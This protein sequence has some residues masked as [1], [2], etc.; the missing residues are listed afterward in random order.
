VLGKPV[1]PSSRLEQCANQ[2]VRPFV[3]VTSAFA[4]EIL[5]MLAHWGYTPPADVFDFFATTEYAQP[6]ETGGN[7]S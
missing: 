6:P 1:Y 3:I 4:H 2:P 5:P 7:A